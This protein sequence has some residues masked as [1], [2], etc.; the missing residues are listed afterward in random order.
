MLLDEFLVSD[1]A[2]SNV[3]LCGV[4]SN[5]SCSLG[6]P[7]YDR[8]KDNMQPL[9][10]WDEGYLET[11]FVQGGLQESQSL[12]Y[13]ASAALGRQSSEKAELCK[14]VSAFANA[15]G[16]M[17]IYGIAEHKHDPTG[18][19]QGVDS[20]VF[21]KEW[22]ENVLTTGVQPKLEHLEI[23]AIDLPSKGRDRVAF[24]IRIGQASA[25]A[26]HQNVSDNKYYRRHNF[27]AEP[28][29]DNEVRDAM[30]RSIAF[31]RKFG[32]AWT[33]LVEVRR[34][35]A[36]A[37][38]RHTMPGNDHVPRTSL[39]IGVSNDLRAAGEAVIFLDRS[40][41]RALAELVG[42]IDE[43]NSTIETVDQGQGANARLTDRLRRRLFE[44]EARA[45]DLAQKLEKIIDEYP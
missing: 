27:K 10:Q 37:G 36:A 28:M 5:R 39:L 20:K 18:T 38:E 3:Q 23:A 32:L 34:L 14:D 42:E 41:R 26:P 19:D 35:R 1:L 22:I 45:R 2:F 43:Y 4:A 6:S 9:A 24:V 25:L 7:E 11:Q 33:L 31:G 15:G 29:Q 17:I 13:K 21:D 16:G 30:R 44:V 8:Q 12:E 40:D